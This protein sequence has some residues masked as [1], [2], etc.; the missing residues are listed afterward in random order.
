MDDRYVAGLFDGEGYVRISRWEKPNSKHIRYQLYLG[1]GMTY[2]PVIK[3]LAK[4]YG[5]T[6]N[7]NRHD[8]RNPKARIQFTWI[9]A[10]QKAASFLRRIEPYSIVKKDEIHIALRLQEHIDTNPY[11]PAGKNHEYERKSR[12]RILAYRERLYRQI[13][14]LKKRSF[15]P[16]L[17]NGPKS[18]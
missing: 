13:A 16:L 15:P 10:S 18:Q 11:I 6:V 9:L 7:Q 2:L 12:T 4:E 1:I 3:M 14:I 17:K 8:L 5:G